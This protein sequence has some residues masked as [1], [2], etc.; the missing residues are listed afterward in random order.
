MLLTMHVCYFCFS[1]QLMNE[2]N[3]ILPPLSSSAMIPMVYRNRMY[4]LSSG[5]AQS[6]FQVNPEKYLTQTVPCLPVPIRIALIGPPKSGKTT[7]LY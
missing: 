5:E 4:Y 3:S 6:N 2:P 7:G 1:V